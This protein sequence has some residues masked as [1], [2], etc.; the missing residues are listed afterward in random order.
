[1]TDIYWDIDVLRLL[2]GNHVTESRE[3]Q[4]G[5]FGRCWWS[6]LVHALL[7]SNSPKANS[8]LWYHDWT[9]QKDRKTTHLLQHDMLFT[10]RHPG[11]SSAGRWGFALF[12]QFHCQ[13]QART[14]VNNI[15]LIFPDIPGALHELHSMILSKHPADHHKARDRHKTN[16]NHSI[17]LTISI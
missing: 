9:P 10:M 16:Q 3:C 11:R 2:A 8:D 7:R 15:S 13:L 4:N 14:H 6:C 1:M 17:N 12:W 5:T